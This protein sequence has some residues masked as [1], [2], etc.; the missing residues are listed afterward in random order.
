M[1]KKRIVGWIQN[2]WFEGI[3][4]YFKMKRP[5]EILIGS[6]KFHS[7]TIQVII[8]PLADYEQ[9]ERDV[10]A[11]L[12]EAAKLANPYSD[13]MVWDSFKKSKYKLTNDS[14]YRY[15]RSIKADKGGT[16]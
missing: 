4:Y 10:K 12:K 15:L 8:F 7:K 6:D 14:I 9:R 16:R 5:V 1:T 11:Q 2:N 3:K 13:D